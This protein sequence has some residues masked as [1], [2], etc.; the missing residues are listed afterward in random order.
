[1]KPLNKL[2]DYIIMEGR[3]FNS[4]EVEQTLMLN[5]AFDQLN[6]AAALMSTFVTPLL[7]KVTSHTK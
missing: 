5:V 3:I 1:M 4:L 2:G 7:G 6:S